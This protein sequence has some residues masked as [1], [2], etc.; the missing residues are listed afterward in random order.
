MQSE[1]W[2]KASEKCKWDAGWRCQVCY[3][4]PPLHAHHRT[5]KRF[6]HEKPGDLTALCEQCHRLFTAYK[7]GLVEIPDFDMAEVKV[8]Y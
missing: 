7:R 5:Y 8:D 2:K 4:E 6:K 1:R 3:A